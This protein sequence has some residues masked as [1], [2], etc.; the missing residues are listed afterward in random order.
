MK[1]PTPLLL[2]PLLDDAQRHPFNHPLRTTTLATV[3]HLLQPHVFAPFVAF[4]TFYP[5]PLLTFHIK[6]FPEL[7]RQLPLHSIA[8]AMALPYCLSITII[9]EDDGI[10]VG[11]FLCTVGPVGDTEL[12]TLPLGGSSPAS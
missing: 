2:L 5:R 7:F 1:P 9:P 8:M 10:L 6:A 3:S 11:I 4:D 12:Y